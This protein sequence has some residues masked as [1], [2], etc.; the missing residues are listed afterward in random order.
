MRVAAVRADIVV[1]VRCVGARAAPLE[2]LSDTPEV[3]DVELVAAEA[4]RVPHILIRARAVLVVHQPA[5]VQ[6]L[7]D[8][9]EQLGAKLFPV[10]FELGAPGEVLSSFS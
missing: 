4:Q 7:L 6:L 3:V 10:L 2:V 9:V 5:R 8:M 1:F